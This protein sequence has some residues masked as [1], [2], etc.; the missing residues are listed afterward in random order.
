MNVFFF[1]SLLFEASAPLLLK[2]NV[3]HTHTRA[4]THTQ[5]PNMGG[6]I[7]KNQ[8]Q[9]GPCTFTERSVNVFPLPLSENVFLM[10]FCLIAV[11]FFSFVFFLEKLRKKTAMFRGL[12]LKSCVKSG[13]AA[14]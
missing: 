11:L 7:K 8:K 13:V 1:L 2:V 4:N 10:H 9:H 3:S 5:I 14:D 6:I 12:K